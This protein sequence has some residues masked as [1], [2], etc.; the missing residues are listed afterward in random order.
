MI[1]R[2]LCALVQS[3]VLFGVPGSH[4]SV[5]VCPVCLSV[6]L[7]VCLCVCLS[8]CLSVRLAGSE[9][10]LSVSGTSRHL[11]NGAKFNFTL[12]LL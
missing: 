1:A 10:R 11:M 5:A 8:V 3:V 7:L 12:Y 4:P 2:T 9:F 6:C